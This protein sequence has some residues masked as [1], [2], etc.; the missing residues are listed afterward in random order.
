MTRCRPACQ[1]VGS[2]ALFAVAA[3]VFVTEPEW[4]VQPGLIG[5]GGVGADDVVTAPDTV[6]AGTSFVVV[7]RTFGSSSCTRPAGADVTLSG[8]MATVV[9][10]DSVPGGRD[11]ICTSDLRAFPRN[12]SLIFSARG[13]G[14]V[15]VTG[16]GNYGDTT[17]THHVVVR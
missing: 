5:V 17:I 9:P 8:L 14:T 12:V 4:T 6:G 7:V 1:L 10:L 3:C 15:A 13:Q 11:V 16:R 2:F